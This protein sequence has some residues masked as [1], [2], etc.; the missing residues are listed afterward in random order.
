VILTGNSLDA[1]SVFHSFAVTKGQRLITNVNFG[2]MGWDLPAVV[3]ACVARQGRR[4]VLI[5]GDGSIAFNS[6][7]L[8]TIGAQKLNALIFVLNNGG[9]QSIRST[10][11]RFSE[12]RLVG[13]DESSGVSNPSFAGLAQA[14][15]L[16]YCR[17][18][19]N[20]QVDERLA[21]LIGLDGPMLCEV[22]VGYAQERIPR[23]VSKR[24]SD[25][26][27]SS[28]ALHDQYPYR[29][30]SEI[31]ANMSVSTARSESPDHGT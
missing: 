31:E 3:G 12:G 17:L 22:N 18:E 2:A 24:Q 29:P 25:G 30:Q 1:H 10:Q 14:Y 15:G 20:D 28:G 6:Q 11:Q 5:T 19:T 16:R 26:T 7:E 8:L 9:Y 13:S 23:V 21:E 27:L 4:V